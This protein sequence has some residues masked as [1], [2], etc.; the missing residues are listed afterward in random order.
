MGPQDAGRRTQGLASRSAGLLD[1]L[2]EG[3]AASSEFKSLLVLH[4]FNDKKSYP[5]FHPKLIFGLLCHP[6][7]RGFHPAQCIGGVFLAC[8][9]CNRGPRSASCDDYPKLRHLPHATDGGRYSLV[10]SQ[11]CSC[12]LTSRILL[13]G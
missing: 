1:W 13:L 5:T 4:L 9:R 3:A 10:G 11:P 7:T 2:V 12:G 8:L 6:A